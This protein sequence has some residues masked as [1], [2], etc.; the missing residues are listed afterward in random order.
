VHEFC[1][2]RRVERDLVIVTLKAHEAELRKLGVQQLYLFGST[3][4]DE[5]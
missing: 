3:A 5:A 1:Y 2:D 4:R